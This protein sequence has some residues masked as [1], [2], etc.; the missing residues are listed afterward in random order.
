MRYA[1]L[2]KV[3]SSEV[4]Q[5]PPQP[6]QCLNCNTVSWIQIHTT[7]CPFCGKIIE[8][9]AKGTFHKEDRRSRVRPSLRRTARNKNERFDNE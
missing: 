3:S 5:I 8:Y 9:T 1:K 6:V 2:A 4:V 7:E